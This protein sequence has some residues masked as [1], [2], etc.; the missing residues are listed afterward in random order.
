MKNCKP[1]NTP[2]FSTDKLSLHDGDP[3]GPKDITEYRSIVGALQYL[4]LTRRDIS[5]AVN[6][7]CQF[8][9]KPTIVYWSVV[10]RILRYLQHTLDM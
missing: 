6:K 2:M 7:V 8:L 9:H 3:L 10:K 4:T 1:M 5:F